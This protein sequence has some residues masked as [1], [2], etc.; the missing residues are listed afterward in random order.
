[1]KNIK[2]L[3]ILLFATIGIAKAQPEIDYNALKEKYKL[4]NVMYLNNQEKMNIEVGD[5]GLEIKSEILQQILMMN[6]QVGS[7]AEKSLTYSDHFEEIN[8]VEALTY[9]P[10]GKKYKKQNVKNIEDRKAS[11]DGIFYDDEKEKYFIFPALQ[12]GAI[13]QLEYE[14]VYKDP[15]FLG[16]FWFDSYV[17]VKRATFSITVPK[18]VKIKYKIFGNESIVKFTQTESKNKTVYTWEGIDMEK[19]EFESDAGTMSNRPTHII[20]YIAEY[21]KDGKTIKVL[22]DVDGFFSWYHSIAKDVNKTKSPELQHLVDSLIKGCTTSEQKVKSIYYWV[23]DHIKYVAFEDGLG[24]YVPRNAEMVCDRRYGDCKDMSS[25]LSSM[26]NTAGID[27]YMTLIGT[28]DIPYTYKDLPTPQMNNHMICAVKNNSEWT[29]LDATFNMIPFGVNPYHIQGKEALIIEGPD[30]YEVYKVPEMDAK[31][32]VLNDSLFLKIENKT[33]KGKGKTDYRGFGKYNL[34]IQL[35]EMASKNKYE[36]LTN[37][38][39]TGNNKCKIDTLLYTGNEERDNPLIMNFDFTLDDYITQVD[40]S[41]FVNMN[42]EKPFQNSYIDKEEKKYEKEYNYKTTNIS[43]TVLEIPKG[44]KL[45]KLPENS[46]FNNEKFSFDFKYSQQ[47]NYIVLERT[48]TLHTLTIEPNMFD[49]W[50]DMISKL[51]SSYKKV[52]E[53]VKTN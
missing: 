44:Y 35:K 26:L 1:M 8:N 25:L 21:E 3:T 33:I 9:V 23:Q 50:N 45:V 40:N 38:V 11:K 22:S 17:P 12:P 31:Y 13:T 20:P 53:F 32:N 34:D 48:I 18:N 7:Y 46:N 52:P 16:S 19:K 27:A 15:H 42:F 4:S 47:G 30:K 28:R 6:D 24:G 43:K 2:T 10:D 5:N 41:I 51:G 39:K 36:R 37:F 49:I 14:Q 29:F